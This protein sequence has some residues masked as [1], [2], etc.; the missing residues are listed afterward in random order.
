MTVR[1][2]SSKRCSV[3][4]LS[5]LSALMLEI[6]PLPD[7]MVW[8]RPHW[9]LLVLLYW[10]LTMPYV[11]SLGFVCV[12]GLVL[13]VL[14]GCLLGEHA[15]AL[16]LLAYVAIKCHQRIMMFH[17]F[18][19]MLVVLL[20]ALLYQSVLLV[21]QGM[22]GQLYYRNAYWFAPWFTALL[23]PWVFTLLQDIQQYVCSTRHNTQ[24]Y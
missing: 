8:L 23:W 4:V 7:A 1:M 24:G 10:L 18:Q 12:V 3:I 9:L 15:L 11:V 6:L 17:F 19:Q 5:A 13:D 20:F 22:I 2:Q 21:I 16:I 14:R